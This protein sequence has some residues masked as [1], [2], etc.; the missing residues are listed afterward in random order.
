MGGERAMHLLTN[1]EDTPGGWCAGLARRRGAKNKWTVWTR[2][3][4]EE[5]G[6]KVMV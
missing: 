6:V 4:E 3:E 2:R 1:R 5:V